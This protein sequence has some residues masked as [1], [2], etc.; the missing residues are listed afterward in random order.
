MTINREYVVKR[1]RCYVAVIALSG[2]GVV[3]AQ[4][5]LVLEEITVTAQKTTEL[6]QDVPVSINAITGSAFEDKV[7]FDLQ[8][9]GKLAPGLNLQSFGS[10]Q[11]ITLRGVGTYIQGPMTPR[12][13][14][15][16]DG[17]YVSQQQLAFF[18]QFDIERYEVLR[19]PQGTLYGTASPTGSIVIHTR[20]PDL[21]RREGYIQQSFG[22][23]QLSNTRFGLSIPVIE[24]QLGLRLAGVYDENNSSGYE[25]GNLDRDQLARTESLRATVLWEP[26]SAVS[27]RL[28][29][30]YVEWDSNNSE[31]ISDGQGVE[32][33]D[34]VDLSDRPRHIRAR[35]NQ[36]I[37]ELNIEIGNTVLTSQTYHAT[38]TNDDD[39]D[40]DVTGVD[41][42]WQTAEI[43]FSKVFSQELRL[44]SSGNDRWDWI[45][46][47]YYGHNNSST[48]V[49]SR[50][51][52][53]GGAVDTTANVVLDASSE[54]WGV[55]THNN[56][57]LSDDWTLT[58]G[59]RWSRV[60]R[61]NLNALRVVGTAN[62]GG[63][64]LDLDIPYPPNYAE[65]KYI[66]LTGTVKLSYKLSIDQMLYLTVDRGGRDGGTTLDLSGTTPDAIENFDHESSTSI[67]LGYK[68]DLLDQR[69]RLN[70]AAFYQTYTD[71]HTQTLGAPLDTDGD[72]LQDNQFD[73][74]QNADEVLV[75]G[76]EVDLTY[77]F[78]DRLRGQLLLSYTDSKYED[79]DDAIC[80]DTSGEL[81]YVGSSGFWVCDLS[82]ER[83]GGD[84]GNWSVV[85]S[86]SY[87]V[88]VTGWGAEWYL[89]TLYNFHSMRVAPI[90]RVESGSFATLDLFTGLRSADG[91]WDL[92][93]WVKNAFDREALLMQNELE[94]LLDASVPSGVIPQ[95]RVIKPRQFGLTGVYRF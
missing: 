90:T 64:V 55:F 80:A 56:F 68:S 84:T 23:H 60:V 22:E 94:T 1:T 2:C 15:F 51:L 37:G 85:A 72:G 49:R 19:G 16:M 62:L 32:A 46:G 53:L 34:R 86:S 43:N 44:A 29:H 92:K 38:S 75:S 10:T 74:I 13:N 83:L 11:N 24:N 50:Q 58:A 69:M 31:W 26:G 40:T 30:S 36:T 9:L 76:A 25:Y 5:T 57:Y 8:D 6:L 18:T 52:R 78:S 89:D 71:F 81:A 35:M 20:N 12:T 42:S 14:V 93:L 82:G 88:P 47:L 63:N 17:A 77:L 39:K 45:T 65:I 95:D 91:Q 27:G 54:N 59:A 67:E 7:S 79:F 4:N 70:L 41:D 48:T 73:V 28:S 66:D 21:T 87:V 3:Q 61:K 33:V